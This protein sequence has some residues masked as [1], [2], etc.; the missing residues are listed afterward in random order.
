MAE[1]AI[2]FFDGVCNLCNGWVQFVLA[3]DEKKYFKFATLQSDFAKNELSRFEV[4]LDALKSVLLLED[5][6]LYSKSTAALRITRHLGS[7]WPILYGFLVVP[8]FIRNGVYNVVARNRYKW[9]GK[10]ESCWIP[11]PELK[12][13]F[14]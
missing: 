8:K 11:T 14:L 5:G 7:G 13:R 3:R 9:F 4:D 12:S 6:K 2:I 1:Q 10:Q